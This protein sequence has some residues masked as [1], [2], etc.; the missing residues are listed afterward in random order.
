[1]CFMLL[2]MYVCVCVCVCVCV[3]VCVCVCVCVCM[4]AYTL[5]THYIA[6]LSTRS[7]SS[8]E[9]VTMEM[10]RL[11]TN[12]QSMLQQLNTLAQTV[13]G[14]SSVSVYMSLCVRLEARSVFLLPGK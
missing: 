8:L 7:G 4:F 5:Y 2:R 14:L 3:Y 1:M 13:S 9:S 10:T 11:Q 12:V 6:A